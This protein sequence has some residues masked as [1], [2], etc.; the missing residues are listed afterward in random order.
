MVVI[1]IITILAAVPARQE[2]GGLL[3][4]RLP[5]TEAQK[6]DGK[7]REPEKQKEKPI[8]GRDERLPV[9]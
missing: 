4:S 5:A 9:E 7:R 8:V 1:A 6:G 2:I 3:S